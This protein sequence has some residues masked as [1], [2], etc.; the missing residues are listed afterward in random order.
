[1]EGARWWRERSP[2]VHL[3]EVRAFWILDRLDGGGGGDVLFT[4][5]SGGGGR[6][7]W[8][9]LFPSAS[10]ARCLHFLAACAARFGN[11][12]PDLVW[13]CEPDCSGLL[14]VA[15]AALGANG[16]GCI[17]PDENL[18]KTLSMP[19]AMASTDVASLLGGAVEEPVATPRLISSDSG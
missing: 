13:L 14:L 4:S 1:M 5:G 2:A 9:V 3:L 10:S 11:A 19:A 7:R 6:R 8:V 12:R 17:D 16:V 15:S 18:A